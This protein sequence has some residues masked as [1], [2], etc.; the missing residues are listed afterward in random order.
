MSDASKPNGEQIRLR[1]TLI[2]ELHSYG[3]KVPKSRKDVAKASHAVMA[4]LNKVK[5]EQKSTQ[6]S[7]KTPREKKPHREYGSHQGNK[8]VHDII[9]VIYNSAEEIPS[10]VAFSLANA[11]TALQ[12]MDNVIDV[13]AMKNECETKDSALDEQFKEKYGNTL[14]EAQALKLRQA[15][16]KNAFQYWTCEIK[17]EM[18][19]DHQFEGSQRGDDGLYHNFVRSKRM[20]TAN[21]VPL[22]WVEA[23]TKVSEDVT[24]LVKGVM[25]VFAAIPQVYVDVPDTGKPRFVS[26]KSRSKNLSSGYGPI[27]KMNLPQ[28]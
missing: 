22:T 15:K 5:G 26:V 12:A 9:D 23:H 11:I 24:K 10:S 16:S 19:A 13:K 1:A 27:G 21:M 3:S 6:P 20:Y 18:I 25:S 17:V 8:H 7:E 4:M 2:S 28:S 14:T